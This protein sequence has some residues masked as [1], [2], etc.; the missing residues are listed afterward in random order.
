MLGFRTMCSRKSRCKLC[1]DS[2]RKSRTSDVT[3][4]EERECA[5]QADKEEEKQQTTKHTVFGITVTRN[6]N[7]DTVKHWLIY[8][9]KFNN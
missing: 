2:E 3:T 4:A 6:S 1:N 5:R 7:I 9:Q 8:V